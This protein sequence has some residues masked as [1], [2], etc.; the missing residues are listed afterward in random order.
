MGEADRYAFREEAWGGL[1]LDRARDRVWSFDVPHFQAART[2]P[3][4]IETRSTGQDPFCFKGKAHFGEFPDPATFSLRAPISVS[5]TC[6]LRC[7]SACIA[8]CTNSHIRAAYGAET[9]EIIVAIDRLADWGVLRLIAGGGEPLLR[10]DIEPVLAHAAARG[11]APALATNGFLLDGATAG[12]LAP[13][14]LQFQ[15]SLDSVRD[16]EYAA[17]R[18]RAG[19]PGL[20]LAAIENAAAT[21]RCVRVVTVLSARNIERIGEIAEAVDRSSASQW[22]VFVVQPAGRGSRVAHKMGLADTST[23]RA[24]VA[25]I[26]QALRPGLPVCFWGDGADDGLSIYMSEACDI[27]VKDYSRNSSVELLAGEYDMGTISLAWD[28]LASRA[29]YA[30]LNNF[31]SADRVL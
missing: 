2:N 25:N 24:R 21:G 8:C 11:L 4:M 23:A 22:F 27:V 31:V 7:Q 26:A 28:G 10:S 5:W 20:A 19:G 1:A 13:H 12:R 9:R 6:T 14:V 17:L 16:D 15:I 3:G 29:K 18:G 30:T